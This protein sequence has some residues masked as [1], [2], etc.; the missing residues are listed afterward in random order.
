MGNDRAVLTQV[1][2]HVAIILLVP[3]AG[4]VERVQLRGGKG[5]GCNRQSHRL[6][7]SLKTSQ[8]DP[9]FICL[10]G[11]LIAKPPAAF[12]TFSE[13]RIVA[14]MR[15]QITNNHFTLICHEYRSPD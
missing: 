13:R 12:D 11:M 5:R 14:A 4:A 3:Q 10:S 6:I 7:Q 2:E 1:G 9:S 15:N 8:T